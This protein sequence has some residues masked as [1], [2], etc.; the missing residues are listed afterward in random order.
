MYQNYRRQWRC[1]TRWLLVV[2]MEIEQWCERV[3][4][5]WV[6]ND[7]KK[8][9][10]FCFFGQLKGREKRA[11]KGKKVGVTRIVDLSLFGVS[12]PFI[13]LN[14]QLKLKLLQTMQYPRCC[15]PCNT[16]LSSIYTYYV[17]ASHCQKGKNYTFFFS[18]IYIWVEFKLHLI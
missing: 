17:V 11:K 16:P 7:L 15:K 13:G 5:F 8:G 18:Y 6:E 9:T 1:G 10:V 14:K 12:F 4:K 2:D 3:F